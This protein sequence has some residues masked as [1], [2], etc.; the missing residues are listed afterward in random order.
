MTIP[1]STIV[2]MIYPFHLDLQFPILKKIPIQRPLPEVVYLLDICIVWI[3]TILSMQRLHGI[4]SVRMIHQAHLH[5]LAAMQFYQRNW[6]E[7][8]NCIAGFPI[9]LK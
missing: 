8:R 9:D 1:I 4:N 5:R 7:I 6:T 3:C 2:G